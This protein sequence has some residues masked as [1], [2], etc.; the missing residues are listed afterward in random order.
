[1]ARSRAPE[2]LPKKGFA[3]FEALA[4][5]AKPRQHRGTQGIPPTAGQETQ[6]A[7]SLVR[8]FGQAKWFVSLGK[9]RNEQAN[10]MQ[11]PKEFRHEPKKETAE[12]STTNPGFP[13]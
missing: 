2:R 7:L 11:Y 12:T 3:L 13:G 5:F 8:F 1:M 10:F 4:E 6:G 9:Q